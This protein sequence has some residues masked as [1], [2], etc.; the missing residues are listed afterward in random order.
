MA[1]DKTTF[2][3]Q[4]LNQFAPHRMRGEYLDW[5]LNAEV[6]EVEIDKSQVE[7]IYPGDALTIVPTST[8]KPKVKA[9]ATGDTIFGFA[10]FNPKFHTWKAGDI[11]SCLRDG[12]TISAVT[13]L[14]IPA[15][16]PVYYTPADGSITNVAAGNPIGIMWSATTAKEGGALCAILVQKPALVAPAA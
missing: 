3:T 5:G 4:D 9:A 14:A 13:E 7:P 1:I 8:G 15:G 2:Y 6:I 12:G 10:L 11:L 16:T